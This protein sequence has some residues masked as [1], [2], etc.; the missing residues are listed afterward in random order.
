[1][2]EPEPAAPPDRAGDPPPTTPGRPGAGSIVVGVDGSPSSEQALRWA[3]DRAARTGQRVHAVIAWEYPRVA[4]V[5][6]NYGVAEISAQDWAGNSR[7]IL[8]QAVAA[9]LTDV[10]AA[11][12][13]QHVVQGHPAKVLLDMAAEAELLVVGSRGHGGFVGMLVGSVSQHLIAHAAC[14]VTVVR[15]PAEPAEEVPAAPATR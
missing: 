9:T 8:D 10:E 6:V 13:Q 5:P 1:M 2:T 7:A 12:V 3:V 11:G 14:P 15:A 4:G